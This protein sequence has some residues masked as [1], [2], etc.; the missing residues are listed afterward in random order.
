M[1]CLDVFFPI[2]IANIV[3]IASYMESVKL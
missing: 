1:L 2:Y 3:S